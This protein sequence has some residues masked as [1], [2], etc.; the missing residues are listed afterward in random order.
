MDNLYQTVID[1]LTASRWAQLK[2]AFERAIDL[3]SLPRDKFV[4]D[5]LKADPDMGRELRNL[6]CHHYFGACDQPLLTK[7][8]VLE[9]FAA[10]L[11]AFQPGDHVAGR[12]LIESFV[13]EGGMGEVYAARD[14][15]LGEVVALKTLRP[16]ISADTRMVESFKREVQLSRRVTHPNVCRVFD[17]FEHQNQQSIPVAFL[18]MQFLQGQTLRAHIVSNGAL[19]MREALQ[20]ALQIADGVDAAHAAGI[21]HGDFKSSNVMLELQRGQYR[22]VITDFGLAHEQ[23]ADWEQRREILGEHPGTPAYMAPEQMAGTPLTA[24]IDIYAMGV[25]LFE[26]ITGQLPFSERGRGTSGLALAPPSPREYAPH[27]SRRWEKAI[28]RCLQP[29]PAK[30]PSG[31]LQA[32]E[33]LQPSRISR[34][35][36]LRTSFLMSSAAIAA[37]TFV[38][39]IRLFSS[40]ND[41]PFN[42]AALASFKRAQEF[43]KR[44]NQE[45]LLNAVD[46]YGKALVYESGR[47]EI[48]IG[49]ADSYSALAN[50]QFM[51]PR[52]ALAKANAAAVKAVQ[53]DPSSGRAQGALAYCLSIDLGQWLRAGPYFRKAVQF[54]PHDA[55]V[56]LWYGAYLA[57][58]GQAEG[59]IAQLKLGLI[60]EPTSLALN[61]QL[62]AEYFFAGRGQDLL[63]QAQELVRLQPFEAAAHLMYARA[64][65]TLGKYNDALES[66]DKAEQYHHSIGALCVRGSIEASRGNKK[67][68]IRIA[69]D[70][71][72]YWRANPFESL[73][74][75]AL[76]AKTK[77]GGKSLDVLLEGCARND[78]SVLFAP[79]HPHLN[80]I[81]NEARYGEF[82]TRIGLSAQ[83]S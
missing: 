12:F 15:E 7:G 19:K 35:S 68:A 80:F 22:A 51:E 41:K 47:A 78:S 82:L 11:R 56:R 13:G 39:G 72:R 34:R 76:H 69:S 32:V 50:F 18:T 42:P 10:G 54:A 27:L 75:A 24:A 30:R 65:E 61:Q 49:L 77:N 3:E 64:L 9:Y 21:V 66:C 40:R 29:D 62:A 57:K 67:I 48:W 46:E 73:L 60:E 25:V 70:V 31:A 63:T 83:S 36:F 44:R 17:L 43:A 4:L 26:M 5:T 28:L 79:Q 33:L 1:K 37:G 81:R 2:C 55:Q 38:P 53:L 45:G 52:L 6:L 8:R 14:M 20:I 16:A 71:E 74:L 58:L 23:R 59:A